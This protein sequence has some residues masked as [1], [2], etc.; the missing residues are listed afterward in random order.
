MPIKALLLDLDDTLL[1]ND[2]SLFMEPYFQALARHMGP[3]IPMEQLMPALFSG[4]RAMRENDGS[5]GTNA[6]V[7]AETFFQQVDTSPDVLLPAFQAFYRQEFQTLASLTEPDAMA[8]P[9]VERSLSEGLQIAIATQPLFPLA[10]IE[11]RLAWANV[12]TDQYGYDLISSYEI[13]RACKPHRAFF[14]QVLEIL[15]REPQEC[16]MVGDSVTSD[17]PASRLGIKTFWVDR[18][19]DESYTGADAQGSLRDLYELLETGAIHE[20]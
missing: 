7:F 19:R 16:L 17:M 6:E 8:A 13:M 15:G 4:T 11:A 9:L 12:G 3:I 5:N 1:I 18:G 10:A 20:L 14:A 2:M